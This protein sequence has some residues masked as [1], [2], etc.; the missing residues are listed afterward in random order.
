MARDN[1]GVIR[2]P[3]TGELAAVRQDCRGKLYFY[4]QAGKIA[5][6]LPAGQRWMQQNMQPLDGF[7]FEETARGYPPKITKKAGAAPQAEHP[8]EQPDQ[9]KKSGWLSEFIG[10]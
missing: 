2:C 10:G 4:S 6:N 8:G 5:P 3:F 9:P 7:E 1:T